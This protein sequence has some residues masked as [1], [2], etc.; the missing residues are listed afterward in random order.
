MELIEE[1]G[2]HEIDRELLIE[3]NEILAIM[4]RSRKTMVKNDTRK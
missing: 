3:A 4:A 1:S 2:I